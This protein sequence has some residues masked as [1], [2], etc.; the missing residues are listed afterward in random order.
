MFEKVAIIGDDDVIFAF[1]ALGIKTISPEN[2]EEAGRKL[3]EL[4]QVKLN[5]F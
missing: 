1:K 5:M 2:L 4:E 3:L